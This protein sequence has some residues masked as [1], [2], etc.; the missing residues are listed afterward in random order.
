MIVS[1]VIPVFNESKTIFHILKKINKIK[2]F[3]KE[4]III[5]DGST[6]N[7]KIIIQKNCLNLY[8]KF[9]SYKKNRGKGYACRKGLKHVRGEVVIIQDADL[10]YDPKD[11][12]KLIKPIIKKKTKIVY[13][14][15]VLKGGVRTRPKFI[16]VLVRQTANHFLTFLS[17]LFNSQNLTDAHTC[18]KVFD[19]SL[20]KKIKLQEDGFNFCPEITAQ[21]SKIKE[22]I[23]EVPINYYGRTHEE[24]KKI[25]FIDGFRA[26]YAIVKY[27][28]FNYN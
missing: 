28:I 13:G 11:Y 21:F 19:S 6:D 24:G 20:L 23:Y 26:I 4:I 17:N 12:P 16:D 8:S 10:E 22:K 27:N 14:S 25:Y 5:D 3:K 2:G 7:T 1:I 18:Y 15:R 9:I